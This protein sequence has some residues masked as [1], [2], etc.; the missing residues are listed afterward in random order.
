MLM[1]EDAATKV[2][3]RSKRKDMVE[4]AHSGVMAAH[5]NAK[6]LYRQI[7]KT[8]FWNGMQADI[9]KWSR[10]CTKCFLARVHEKNTPPLKPV[11]TTAPFEL[12]GIDL[13]VCPQEETVTR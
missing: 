7:K 12:V 8:L 11:V 5:L 10:A 4:E 6:K 3:P 2:V 13:V 9:E 1:Y